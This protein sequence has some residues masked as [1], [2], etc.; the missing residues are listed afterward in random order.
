M[1]ASLSGALQ[2]V[3]LLV[4]KGFD[5][6][7]PDATGRS[8]YVWAASGNHRDVADYF[9]KQGK[10]PPA[11]DP[12]IGTVLYSAASWGRLEVLEHDAAQSVD[13]EARHEGHTPVMGAAQGGHLEVV[14]WLVAHGANPEGALAL[15]RRFGHQPVAGYLAS[16]SAPAP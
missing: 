9:W 5:P 16:I 14:R 11:K 13:L 8:A 12:F 2:V 6:L 15:A 10:R 4:D 7:E 1:A 3:R